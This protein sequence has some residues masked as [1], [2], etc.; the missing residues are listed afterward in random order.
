VTSCAYCG[1]RATVH[2]P[3]NPEHVCRTHAVEFWTGL[4]AYVKDRTDPCETPD[5][6]CT[7]ESCNQLSAVS[8]RLTAVAAG[9]AAPQRAAR[10]S[11][12][13]SRRFTGRSPIF[14]AVASSSDGAASASDQAADAPARSEGFP[15]RAPAATPDE[16]ESQGDPESVTA[17]CSN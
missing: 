9:G 17:V 6:P 7:C 2:I 15:V 16:F 13:S 14:T 12:A 11:G 1:Q 5:T 8:A 3:S 10:V 4:M